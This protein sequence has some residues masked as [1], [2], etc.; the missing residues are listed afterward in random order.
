MYAGDRVDLMRWLTITQFGNF[1]K[2][3]KEHEPNSFVKRN[4]FLPKI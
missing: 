4:N 3:V 1:A 2:H